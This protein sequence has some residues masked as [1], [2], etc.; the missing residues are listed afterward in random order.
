ML[1]ALVNSPT[2]L[3][4]SYEQDYKQIVDSIAQKLDGEQEDGGAGKRNSLTARRQKPNTSQNN[5]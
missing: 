2:A 4:E 3:F 5:P 1:A